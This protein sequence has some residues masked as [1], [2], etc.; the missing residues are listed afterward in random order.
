MLKE[1]DSPKALAQANE[2][3][4]MNEISHEELISTI[5]RELVRSSAS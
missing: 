2:E 3:N 4:P 1:A 5:E